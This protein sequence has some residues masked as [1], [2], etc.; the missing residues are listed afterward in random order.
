MSK[1][2]YKKT[3][4]KDFH[5]DLWDMPEFITS[6]ND[7]TIVLEP[8]YHLRPDK[9]SNDLYGTTEYWWVFSV[10]NP[11]VLIDPIHDFVSG[12]EIRVPSKGNLT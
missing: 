1:G 9:L 11:D 5:L 7:K 3:P 8:K 6:L 12:I 4:I 2:L 10:N